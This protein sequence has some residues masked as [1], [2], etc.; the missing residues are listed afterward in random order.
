MTKGGNN[1]DSPRNSVS[2]AMS[3]IQELKAQGYDFLLKR[4]EA[5]FERFRP[6]RSRRDVNGNNIAGCLAGL[7]ENHPFPHLLDVGERARPLVLEVHP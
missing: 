7:C 1:R 2:D 4:G 5:T 3:E 6:F